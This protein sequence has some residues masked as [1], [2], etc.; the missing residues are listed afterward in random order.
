LTFAAALGPLRV[1]RL[2]GAPF[3]VAAGVL[4]IAMGLGLKGTANSEF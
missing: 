3:L 2:P 1:W 4:V